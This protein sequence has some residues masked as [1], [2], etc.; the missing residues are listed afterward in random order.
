MK[1]AR[2]DLD[3]LHMAL[4]R[5]S[6]DDGM[7]LDVAT[8]EAVSFAGLEPELAAGEIADLDDPAALTDD[9]VRAAHDGG[10][11]REAC[12]DARSSHPFRT[13]A[14]Q[15]SARR[16]VSIGD[17]EASDSSSASIRTSRAGKV[18]Q[19]STGHDASE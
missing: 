2:V 6:D 18:S 12:R 15:R 16:T 4:T 5:G 17:A 7:Y 11:G 14:R 13:A 8:G 9:Q 3:D 10:A 19:W 1:G